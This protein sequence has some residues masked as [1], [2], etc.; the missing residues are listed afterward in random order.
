[1]TQGEPLFPNIFNVVMEAVVRHLE[2]L[3]EEWDGGDGRDNS[4]GNE[5]AQPERRTVRVWD[6]GKRQTEGGHTRLKVQAELF[7]AY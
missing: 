5:V 3:V 2:S 1:M 4:S 6:D 7:C